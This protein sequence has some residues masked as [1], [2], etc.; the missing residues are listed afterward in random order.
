MKLLA[1]TVA[2]IGWTLC[3]NAAIV[4]ETEPND[5]L[6]TGTPL[7]SVSFGDG[8]SGSINP[9]GDIDWFSFQPTFTS[10]YVDLTT[11]LTISLFLPNHALL[12]TVTG[13]SLQLSSLT[14]GSTYE[15]ELNAPGNNTVVPSYTATFESTPVPEPSCWALLASVGGGI[16]ALRRRHRHTA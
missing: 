6:A 7:G 9:V 5:T 10:G 4:A 1:F 14:A 13:S 12:T 16:F 3:A 15:L 11:P 8:A 2:L